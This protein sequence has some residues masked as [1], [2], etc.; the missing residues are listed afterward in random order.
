MPEPLDQTELYQRIIAKCSANA[1]FKA[2]LLADPK[3]VLAEEG[4]LVQEGKTIKIIEG[5]EYEHIF[6]IPHDDLELKIK[7]RDIIA[8][9][10]IHPL[11]EDFF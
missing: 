9:P 3:F 8:T 1:D 10:R 5:F 6:L 2:K 4:Y 11:P 7:E